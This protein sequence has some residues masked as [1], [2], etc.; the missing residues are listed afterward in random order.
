MQSSSHLRVDN[1]SCMTS[2]QITLLLSTSFVKRILA[3]S[4][5][6][7]VSYMVSW[8]ANKMVKCK[9]HLGVEQ[10]REWGWEV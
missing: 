5:L 9:A 1:I 8:K 3:L 7:G 2:G 4:I 10:R 6:Q